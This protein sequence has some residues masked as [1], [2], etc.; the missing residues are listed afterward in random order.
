[1]LPGGLPGFAERLM[2]KQ[3]LKRFLICLI[4][5]CLPTSGAGAEKMPQT[6]N[7][8]G[9]RL[10][11]CGQGLLEWA[12]FLDIYTA[13]F[14]LDAEALERWPGIKGRAALEI[15]YDYGFKAS[16]LAEGADAI[17]KKQLSPEALSS[18]ETQTES[19]HRAYRDVKPG[20]RYRLS[21]IPEI[22]SRLE[23]NGELLV[24]VPGEEFASAYFGIWLGDRGIDS[25]LAEE[26]L[27]CL[28]AAKDQ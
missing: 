16:E 28:P 8:Q 26:L 15:L 11:L 22:G 10:P 9:H 19:L 12:G 18:L 5:L 13:A 24:T 1:L 6:L 7:I 4:L 21:Y 25:E 2:T 23:L 27:S 3:H 17:L 20:D 14:Y